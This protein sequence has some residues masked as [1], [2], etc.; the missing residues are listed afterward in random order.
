LAEHDGICLTRASGSVR[1]VSSA[2]LA[3]FVAAAL[4]GSSWGSSASAPPRGSA[5]VIVQAQ[6][7]SLE[8][9]QATVRRLGGSVGR[10]L[11]IV[12]GFSA[13]IPRSALPALR[14]ADGVRAVTLDT[15]VR[16]DDAG[17]SSG[18]AVS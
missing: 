2:A 7:G 11:P 1:A 13:R 16:A 6:P 4:A 9:V 5:S 15:P 12:Q 3:V 8:R 18:E 17:S 14:R 10:R